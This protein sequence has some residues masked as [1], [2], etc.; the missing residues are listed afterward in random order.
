MAT[1]LG[2]V[3]GELAARYGERPALTCRDVSVSWAELEARTNRR[4]RQFQQLGVGQ[5]GLV[6]IALPNGIEFF[7]ATIAAWKAGA[8]PQPI[9]DRL[10][11]VE[12][13]ALVELA[14]PQLVVGV[15]ADGVPSLPAGTDPPADLDDSPLAPA[16]ARSLKA[17]ASG[18][19][20]GRPKLIVHG[21]PAVPEAMGG[22][23]AM[24]RMGEGGTH[25]VTGPLHHN[26]PFL[27][28][29]AGLLA[30]NHLVVL[31]RFDAREALL[32][33][34]RHSVD[35][36]YAVPTMMQ[37]IWRLPDEER[38]GPDLSS[39]RSVLHLAAPCP[40]WLKQAWIDW[41]GPDKILELYAGTEAQAVTFLDGV[42]WLAHPGSVGK[43][44]A[45]EMVV[46]DLDGQPVPPGTVGTVWMRPADPATA[47]YRYVGASARSRP[48]GWE[49]LGDLGWMDGD[50]YLYLTDRDTDM[51]LVGGSNVY[52]AEI[53]GALLDHPAVADA[54][55]V[56]L[57]DEDLGSRP[58]AI[59]HLREDASDDELAAHVRARLAPY[60][61]PRTWERVDEPLRDDAGKVRRSAL[62][63]ARLPAHPA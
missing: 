48:E 53:E 8:T 33:I 18:G 39:L 26:G 61:C 32:A 12:R 42:E 45:G 11:P 34:E 43:V 19:S 22:V 21:A 38:L 4:A 10:P 24:A 31:P 27:F 52:P 60:K 2:E 15:A 56:G 62:R 5:D 7:E 25:L 6:G 16:I 55:V 58:H 23:V 35:W 57:P 3:L 54:C 1:A 51:I 9:S 63:A 30:G 41:L 37:R 47:T 13:A 46:L 14:A 59:V 17:L 28:G 29:M 49:T 40:P 50:G 20:T 44:V 36:M